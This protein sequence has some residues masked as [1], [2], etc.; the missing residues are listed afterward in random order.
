MKL[1]IFIKLECGKCTTKL[2]KMLIL[3]I[4]NY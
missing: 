2:I 4:H 1:K 3:K